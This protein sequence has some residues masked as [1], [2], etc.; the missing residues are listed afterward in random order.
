MDTVPTL[1]VAETTSPTKLDLV[2]AWAVKHRQK[3]LI[4]LA[5]LAAAVL[6]TSLYLWQKHRTEENAS[7]ELSRLRPQLTAEGAITPVPAAN[8]LLI[9]ERYPKT[10]AGLRARLLAAG[11]LFA[12]GRFAEA[13]AQFDKFIRDYPRSQFREDALYGSATCLTAQGKPGEAAAIYKE[14]IARSTSSPVALRAKLALG[15]IYAAQNKLDEARRLFE[16][17]ARTEG[18]GFLAYQAEIELE[19]LGKGS[20]Q[21]ASVPRPDAQSQAHSPP[22]ANSAN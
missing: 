7:A 13:K 22:S 6:A 10:A 21:T 1:M 4:G 17:V 15:R 19:Q 2:L 14:I 3:L 20:V 18:A 11:A 9:A 12:E 8:Y 5:V 16:E